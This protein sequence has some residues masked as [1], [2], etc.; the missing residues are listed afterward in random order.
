MEE[1][2][3]KNMI[4]LKNLPSNLIEEAFVIVKSTKKVKKLDKIERSNKKKIEKNVKQGVDENKEKNKIEDNK[5]IIKEAE[6]VISSYIESLGK[7]ENEMKNKT[8]S[9]KKYR[10]LKIYSIIATII[11]IMQF[12][13]IN[14]V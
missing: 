13:M 5:Y 9:Y 6:I 12:I 1:T 3:M 2:K 7:E 11:I 4:V 14:L 8:Q 10:R